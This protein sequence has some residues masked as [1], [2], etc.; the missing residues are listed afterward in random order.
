[1]KSNTLV[2]V[3]FTLYFNSKFDKTSHPH[4]FFL[5][6][7]L[8]IN[9]SV[10]ENDNTGGM[11]KEVFGLIPRNMV[12]LSNY[13]LSFVV[14]HNVGVFENRCLDDSQNLYHCLEGCLKE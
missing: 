4:D 2:K 6:W 11:K 10:A 1:M 3:L 5:C 7:P 13:G 8:F 14:P 9:I 12:T